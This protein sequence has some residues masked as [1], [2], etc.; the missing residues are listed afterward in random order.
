LQECGLSLFDAVDRYEWRRGISF[1]TYAAYW[2]HERAM[3]TCYDRHVVRVPRGAQKEARRAASIASTIEDMVPERLSE[4]LGISC[5]R[6]EYLLNQDRSRILSIY[7]PEDAH[8]EDESEIADHLEDVDYEVYN[9]KMEDMSAKD[10]VA[11][12]LELLIDSDREVVTRYYGLGREAQTMPSIA[13]DLGVSS[14]RIQQLH[15]RAL[16]KMC[17]SK[18]YSISEPYMPC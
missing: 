4:Q 11:A 16:G 1:T 15:K 13:K 17:T 7:G 3:V 6:A 18:I 8:C 14:Q 10:C 5:A 2:V 9:V 12:A